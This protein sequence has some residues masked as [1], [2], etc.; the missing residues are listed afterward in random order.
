MKWN[1]GVNKAQQDIVKNTLWSDTEIAEVLQK[2]GLE[3]D[4]S[5]AGDALRAVFDELG[6]SRNLKDVGVGR[7]QWDQLAMNSLAD[8]AVIMNPR[9]MTKAQEV[10]EILEMCSDD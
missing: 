5:D 4:S 9:P 10:K 6:M 8:T 2:H 3:K 1:A 7:D